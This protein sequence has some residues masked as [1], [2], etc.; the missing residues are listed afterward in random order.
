MT[1]IAYLIGVDGGGTKTLVR[2]ARADGSVLAQ[3]SGPGSALRNGATR[4]WRAIEDTIAQAF[5][6]VGLTVPAPATLAVGIGIAGQNVVQWAADFQSQAPHFGALQ[7]VNDGVAT[8]LGAHGGEPGAIIA[9]GTG[10]IGIALDIDG[11]QRVVDGWG[12]PSGDDGSGAWI[13]LRALHHAQHALDGRALRGPL[14]DAMLALCASELP[15][16]PEDSGRDERATLLDWLAQ[17][18]QAA[19][20]R[21]ARPVVQHAGLDPAADAILHAAGAEISLMV[22]ALDPLQ[23]LPLALCGGLAQALQT[24]LDAGLRQRIVPARA[25]AA[26]GALLLARQGMATISNQENPA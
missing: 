24:Y 19:F 16:V 7:I 4:A 22:A 13:G 2:L 10:T 9:V 17:A 18:D 5:A 8:L 23:R 25:D 1:D 14:A 12:F 26:D 15:A 3:A 6:H 20:A 11:R 21:A